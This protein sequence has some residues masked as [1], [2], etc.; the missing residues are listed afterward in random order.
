M[1]NNFLI[2]ILLNF[3]PLFLGAQNFQTF[4]QFGFGSYGWDG[5][6]AVIE[7]ADEG[8]L[9]CSM[10]NG[11]ISADKTTINYGET[12]VWLIKTDKNGNIEWQKSYGGSNSDQ[13][14]NVIQTQ[15]GNYIIGVNSTSSISGNKTVPQYGE[16]DLWLIKI[17]SFGNI[18]WQ[19]S[20]G[21]FQDDLFNVITE[22]ED[23]SLV[24][25]AS[26]FSSTSGTKQLPLKG[27]TDYW[28]LFLDKNGNYQK[29]LSFAGDDWNFA[30]GL[31]ILNDN[32]MVISGSSNSTNAIDKTE[33]S[34]GS[35][36]I[37]LVK[38]DTNGNIIKDK[39]IG[40]T[41]DDYSRISVMN[42]NSDII[43]CGLTNSSISGNKSSGTYGVY[44]IW[45]VKVDTNLNIIW[46]KTFGGS[47]IEEPFDQG[48]IIHSDYHNMTIISGF[49]NSPADGNKTSI[50][51]GDFDFWIIGI[52]ND[53]NKVMELTMGGN[54][55][56]KGITC[57]ETSSHKI[58]A[59][60]WSASG[61]T[62]N[63][64]T[65]NKGQHD[66]W[67]VQL[68]IVL[69]IENIEPEDLSIY[70]VPA[71][72]VLNF[73]IPKASSQT[74]AQII[75]LQGQTLLSKKCDNLTQDQFNIS[76]LPSGTYFLK[77]TTP[78]MN[79][80]RTFIIQ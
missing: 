20:Y 25:S 7:T 17:D 21:G 59:L 45:M 30:T 1:N 57:I 35:F 11:D 73:S 8:F 37:W 43:L 46:D 24:L 68:D 71:T 14:F 26:T 10:S 47:Q 49:S 53:G 18:I 15:D 19:K 28:H 50:N 27:T 58:M 38:S 40:G 60:G 5:G 41:V 44:D 54:Q 32:S 64:I 65:V 74:T 16:Y 55:E 6:K 80:S 75:N 61:A 23:G 66:T 31:N 12:D 29:E 72:T 34:F 4:S 70:P 77:I 67:A 48:Q 56:D 22:K 9:F 13:P 3:A 51:H 69:S 76:H 63:K 62:G 36:D 33:P 52:D 42:S 2:L 79:Y 78:E 39:T